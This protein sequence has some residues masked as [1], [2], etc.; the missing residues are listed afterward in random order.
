MV[1]ETKGFTTEY[2][3]TKGLNDIM[4]HAL[5]NRLHMVDII[6]EVNATELWFKDYA[7]HTTVSYYIT[8]YGTV[9]TTYKGV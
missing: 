8:N 7:M 3:G 1:L 5:N 9:E 6:K 4:K 2:Q